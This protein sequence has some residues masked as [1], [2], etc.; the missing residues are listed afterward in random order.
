MDRAIIS[1]ADDQ[2]ERNAALELFT[3]GESNLH[4]VVI[5]AV[6]SRNPQGRL[7]SGFH[8]NDERHINCEQ[9]PQSLWR[10]T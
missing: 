4:A 7:D 1:Q 9:V 6:V 8:R 10:V 5:P 2:R 3:F